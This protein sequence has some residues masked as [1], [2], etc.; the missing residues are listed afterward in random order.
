MTD[1]PHRTAPVLEYSIVG[2]GRAHRTHPCAVKC[3]GGSRH[4]SAFRQQML[5]PKHLP[6]SPTCQKLLVGRE[7]HAQ[8]EE[9]YTADGHLKTAKLRDCLQ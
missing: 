6:S 9:Q 7:A 4:W 5:P 1:N 3:A 2:L 8:G